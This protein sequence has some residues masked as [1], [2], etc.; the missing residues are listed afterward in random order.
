VRGG[1][2]IALRRRGRPGDT[3]AQESFAVYAPDLARSLYVLSFQLNATG[4]GRRDAVEILE[5]AIGIIRSFVL[6][7][8]EH[9]DLY[10]NMKATLLVLKGQG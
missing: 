6:P 10:D 3:L 4:H 8:T 9:S 5:R 2:R 7:N 1:D